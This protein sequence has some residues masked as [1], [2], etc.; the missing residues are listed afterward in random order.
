M[1]RS[2]WL[3]I[4]WPAHTHRRT[5]DGSE[6]TYV[7]IGSGPALVFVHGLGGSWQNW[8]ENLPHFAATH[9]CIAMDLGG[10][11][12]SA[13]VDGDVSIERFARSVRELLAALDIESAAV[14]GNSM[15]GFI[16]LELAIKFPAL[17][18]RLVLVSAAV[19]WQE[20]RRAKP[21]VAF[22]SATEGTLGRAMIGLQPRLAARP[23]LRQRALGFGGIRAPHKLPRELQRELVLT[24]RRTEGFLPAFQALASYSLRDE[25]EKVTAPTLIV[26]GDADPLVGVSHARELEQLIPGARAVIY[27]RTGHVVQLERPERFNADVEAFLAGDRA[28]GGARDQARVLP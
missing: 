7:D 2:A 14:I 11:G 24:A 9:R 22:A 18:E 1:T 25:L 8:L 27:E 28:L 6:M 23:K 13:P 21:L 5:I 20:Y 3:D 26:W 19:L 15:G 4:D 12:E 17:V 16:A 10:F